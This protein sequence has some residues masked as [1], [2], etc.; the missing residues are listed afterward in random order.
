MDNKILVSCTVLAY[1]S[2]AT[3]LE[4][5]ES[6][7]QQTYEHIELI[8][9]DD[10][11]TDNTVELCK[12]WIEQNGSRFVR[13]ELLTVEKNTGVSANGNRALAACNGE[14]Q[15][16]IAADDI[17]LPNCVEDFVSFVKKNPNAKWLS[18]YIRIYR[19]SFNEK[20]CIGRNK[21]NRPFFEES[22]EKQL[23]IMS[24]KNPIYGCAVFYN[25]TLK[26]EMGGYD[27]S[28]KIEDTPFFIKLLEQGH[29]CYFLEKE[30]VGYR[31]HESAVNSN[32]R[33]FNYSAVL[34]GRRIR[35]DLSFKYLTRKEIFGLKLLWK[36]QDLIEKLGV[37]N[38]KNVIAR[39]VYRIA[40]YLTYNIFMSLPNNKK[41]IAN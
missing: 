14:W 30:T 4:T 27:I 34:E 31:I 28:Y 32:I 6:I 2:S 40:Y 41:K 36:T 16:G 18:S 13:A 25:T 21:A 33:L 24:R 12:R 37:N 5:L 9:S 7:K 11:S 8:V 23:W 26:K 3:V 29:K 10:C 17:L 38:K 19:N 15:A 22:V 39:N 20:N 35:K 1:N